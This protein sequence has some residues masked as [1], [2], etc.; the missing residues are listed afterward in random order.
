M[1]AATAAH[2]SAGHSAPKANP[3][4][5]EMSGAPSRVRLPGGQLLGR[6]RERAAVDRLLDGGRAGRGGVLVVH[7][8]PGIGKTALPECALEAGREFRGGA[9]FRG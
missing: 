3:N 2:A 9:H 8:E 4:A 1:S 7:G 6:E 5:D